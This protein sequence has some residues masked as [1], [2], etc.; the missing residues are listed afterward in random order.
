MLGDSLKFQ[1]A[2]F[3]SL[4]LEAQWYMQMKGSWV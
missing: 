3:K 1:N 2:M 4:D